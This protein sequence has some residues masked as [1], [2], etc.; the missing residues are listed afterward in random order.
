M[1][2]L[3]H[4]SNISLQ[5]VKALKSVLLNTPG[6]LVVSKEV[7]LL[8]ILSPSNVFNLFCK[9]FKS[10]VYVEVSTLLSKAVSTSLFWGG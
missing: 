3:L 2:G 8:L 9:E 5:L 6:N 1:P 7:N 10:V 4:R